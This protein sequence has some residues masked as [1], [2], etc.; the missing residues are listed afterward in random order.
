MPL[1]R[2]LCSEENAM[3]GHFTDGDRVLEFVNSHDLS[4]LAPLGTSCP[5]HF[6]RTKIQPLVLDLTPDESLDDLKAIKEKITGLLV[7]N[8][9]YD[10]TKAR[11][12]IISLDHPEHDFFAIR[13]AIEVHGDGQISMA[14]ELIEKLGIEVPQKITAIPFS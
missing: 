11:E 4:K 9:T 3:I 14:P 5:D 10:A 8:R 13:A 7:D 2:G 12:V 1:L 6:L